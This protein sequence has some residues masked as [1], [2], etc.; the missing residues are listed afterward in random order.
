[1][2]PASRP[3]GRRGRG[4][5][6]P[7][8]GCARRDRRCRRRWPPASRGLRPAPRR[9][10]S[11]RGWSWRRTARPG[12]HPPCAVARPRAKARPPSRD[13]RGAGSSSD[14]G[15]VP[16]ANGLTPAAP[17]CSSATAR[18]P[19]TAKSNA[20]AFKSPPPRFGRAAAP[21]LSEAVSPPRRVAAE[22][23]LS[24]CTK[25][26]LSRFACLRH[27][28]MGSMRAR[29]SSV[30]ARPYMERFRAFRAPRRIRF[31]DTIAMRFKWVANNRGV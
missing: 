31:H 27:A 13:G 8:R 14:P 15:T 11:R 17:K 5:R 25:L 24:D 18:V 21:A 19:A 30:P 9:P 2:T 16:P 29:S 10:R 12:P 3:P 28:V 1:V 20:A 6:R 26:A 22:R 4:C 7:C 23:P